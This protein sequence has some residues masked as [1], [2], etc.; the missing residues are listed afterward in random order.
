MQ[1]PSD[2]CTTALFNHISSMPNLYGHP[3]FVNM[4]I[5]SKGFKGVPQDLFCCSRISRPCVPRSASKIQTTIPRIQKTFCDMV[6]IYNHLHFFDEKVTVPNK[7]VR[8][9]RLNGK[10]QFELLP[11]FGSDG[12]RTARI[13]I[14]IAN[15]T[16]SLEVLELCITL[17]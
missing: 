12:H 13:F 10:H 2:N 16:S 17:L 4:S 1:E 8:Q 11:K 5:L 6:Q 7:I 9:I 15:K 3:N 14:N